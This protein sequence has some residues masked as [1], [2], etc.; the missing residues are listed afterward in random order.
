[1]S[2]RI[3]T[4]AGAGLLLLLLAAACGGASGEPG[5]P[6]P[7]DPLP[8]HPAQLTPLTATTAFP[9]FAPEVL[10]SAGYPDHK[11][12]FGYPGYELPVAADGQT[13]GIHSLAR[14]TLLLPR[15][16]LVVAPG[17]LRY[18]HVHLQHA[19]T[20]TPAGMLP[21]VEVLD[22]AEREVTALLGF[23]RPDTLDVVCPADLDLYRERTGFGFHRLYR[24]D[25]AVAVLEPPQVLFARGLALHAAFHL[26]TVWQLDAL[27]GGRTLPCWFRDGLAS[28]FAEDG[29]HFLSYL[30]MY[31]PKGPVVLPF[32]ETEAILAGPPDPDQET[33]KRRIRMAGYSAYLMVWELVE[34]RGGLETVRRFL[35]RV[36]AGEAP[37]AV[38]RDLWG[39]ALHDLAVDLDATRRPEPV[40]DAV[41]A[42]Q[43]NRP[44][45]S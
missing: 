13:Y 18:R 37:D 42:R 23:A 10:A 28:Y 45:S 20:F 41:Q 8:T 15:D 26:M 30:A 7:P 32:A 2:L 29:V 44:P 39:Y 11:H 33:D 34:N 21:A 19:E 12:V 6:P 25:G 4:S 1:M 9:R 36:H 38:S 43:V 5:P 24:Y 16:G 27:A 35:H 3:G 17:D 40:G 14:G 31:R 22:W